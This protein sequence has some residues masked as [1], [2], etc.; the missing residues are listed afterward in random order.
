[1]DLELAR[2]V[3]ILDLT[4]YSP[5]VLFALGLLVLSLGATYFLVRKAAPAEE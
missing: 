4:K 5:M 1:V 2:K 3:I